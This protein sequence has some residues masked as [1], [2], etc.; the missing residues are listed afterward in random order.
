MRRKVNSRVIVDVL[1]FLIAGTSFSVIVLS[2]LL[3]FIRDKKTSNYLMFIMVFLYPCNILSDQRIGLYTVYPVFSCI[4]YPL[5]YFIGAL[6]FYNFSVVLE[7][8]V[9]VKPWAFLLFLPGIISLVM[10]LPYYFADPGMKTGTVWF[11]SISNGFLRNAYPVMMH[12]ALIWV[13]IC[14]ILFLIR[15][16]LIAGNNFFKLARYF[17]ILYIYSL[18]WMI[19]MILW[20]TFNFLHNDI[21]Y[22]LVTLSANCL[23]IFAFFIAVRNPDILKIYQEEI[24]AA[25]YK[26]T[27]IRGMDVQSVA[28]RMNELMKYDKIYSDEDLDLQKLS[29]L[30]DI[31]PHQLSEI[32]NIELKT[33]FKTYL[34]KYRIDAAKQMLLEDDE[35][36][37]LRIAF[38][39]GFKSKSAFNAAFSKIS[40]YTPSDFR[41][42]Y[43][44]K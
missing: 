21:V 19:P 28:A 20:V 31:N 18:L 35:I 22:K 8:G 29:G 13:N 27:K 16:R 12:G 39:C 30:L 2:F 1:N 5:E 32:F 3:L 6:L 41:E 43:L 25:K 26:K 34:N 44:K 23:C 37:I 33:S 7:D 36:S 4:N 9:R 11:D 17:K 10:L 24:R 14:I 42:S 38:L 40:G 15:F